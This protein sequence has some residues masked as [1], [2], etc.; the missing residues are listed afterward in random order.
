M[1]S[2]CKP[3]DICFSA[4][5]KLKN[6]RRTRYIGWAESQEAFKEKCKAYFFNVFGETDIEI[7]S[8]WVDTDED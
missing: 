6:D 3:G 7:L 2:I 8:I 4:E 5:I 1:T